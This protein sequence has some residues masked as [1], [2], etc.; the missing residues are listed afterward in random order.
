MYDTVE[1]RLCYKV[2]SISCFHRQESLTAEQVSNLQER[3]A[4]L[5]V[6]RSP[7]ELILHPYIESDSLIYTIS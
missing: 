6:L 3:V 5:K 4:K 1:T 7:V 2:G